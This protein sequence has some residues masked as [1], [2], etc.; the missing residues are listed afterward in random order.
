M[1]YFNL[2]KSCVLDNDRTVIVGHSIGQL[3]ENEPLLIDSVD[4]CLLVSGTATMPFSQKWIQFLSNSLNKQF[5]AAGVGSQTGNE[6]RFCVI[7]FG[8]RNEDIRARI[9]TV[10]GDVFFDAET[11]SKTRADLKRNGHVADGYEAIEFTINNIPFRKSLNVAKGII[12]VTDTGRSV[13]ADRV[14]LTKPIVSYLL[15]KSNISLDV[16]SNISVQSESDHILGM[17]DYHTKVV[18]QNGVTRIDDH[19]QVKIVSSHGDTLS[20]YAELAFH[21]GGG[22]WLLG[23]FY[24]DIKNLLYRDYIKGIAIEYV[25]SRSYLKSNV[26]EICSCGKKEGNVSVLCLRPSNQRNCLDKVLSGK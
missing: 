11:V 26:C 20:S 7:Q 25:N 5:M 14:N 21:T 9:I 3:V 13:L 1:L 16:I 2:D 4:I 12:L 17:L 23:S 24:G 6:N 8:S 15:Q 18:Y 10:N 22:A 19:E